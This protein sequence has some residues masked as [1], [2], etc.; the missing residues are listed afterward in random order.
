MRLKE[1]SLLFNII[2]YNDISIAVTSLTL[3]FIVTI[4]LFTN[5]D[6]EHYR[7][8][9]EKTE[10]TQKMQQTDVLGLKTKLL[11]IEYFDNYLAN[12]VGAE[13]LSRWD[14][15]NYFKTIEGEFDIKHLDI[16]GSKVS[17]VTNKNG[18]FYEKQSE[19]NKEELLTDEEN[20]YKDAFSPKYSDGIHRFVLRGRRF[21]LKSIK[22]IKGDENKALLMEIPV[23]F[24]TFTSLKTVI[25][26]DNDIHMV[27]LKDG[28]YIFGNYGPFTQGNFMG[29]ETKKVVFDGKDYMYEEVVIGDL[30]YSLGYFPLTNYDGTVEA[31][32]GVGLSQNSL[33]KLKAWIFL[34]IVLI[35]LLLLLINSYFFSRKFSRLLSPLSELVEATNNI[36]KGR[37]DIELK[38]SSTNEINNLSHSFK[39]MIKAIKSTETN[40]KKQNG[41]LIKTLHKINVT[42]SLLVRVRGERD[43]SKVLDIMLEGITSDNGL[44]FKRA[45]LFK[46]SGERNELVGEKA[47]FNNRFFSNSDDKNIGNRIETFKEILPLIKIEMNKNLFTT[48]LN[49]KEISYYNDR[50]YKY[51]FGNDLLMGFGINNFVIIP[52]LVEDEKYGAIIADNYN[53]EIKIEDNDIDLLH[54]ILMNLEVHFKNKTHEAEDVEKNREAAIGK[55]TERY[56]KS[57]HNFIDK[58]YDLLKDIRLDQ[59]KKEDAALLELEAFNVKREDEV[60]FEY[61]SKKAFQ[62]EKLGL[63]KLIEDLVREAEPIHTQ[64]GISIFSS[65]NFEILGDK[66]SMKRAIHE[67]LENSV[68]AINSNGGDG[69]IK[70]YLNNH[71]GKI[72]LEIVD[73]GGG[74]PKE[75]MSDKLF[76]PFISYKAKRSGL[77]LAYVKKVIKS[78]GGYVDLK[79]NNKTTKIIIELNGYKE[80]S[81]NVWERLRKNFKS[82]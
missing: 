32:I 56:L 19:G 25:N 43:N 45:F 78:H 26:N 55:I 62:F 31:Y 44:G 24:N 58:C 69:E 10:L 65:R 23:D 30:E 63:T 16:E 42:E 9:M 52:I 41:R 40:L 64:I 37:Y 50:G 20:F 81:K 18:K 80:E 79:S 34:A 76:E 71:K 7:A 14:K 29:N 22:K 61:S 48:A 6:D 28:K 27:V 59:V 35:T 82:T 8:T 13:S 38:E 21:H 4:Y 2:L 53:S 5:L 70:I 39:K 36:S 60:L 66:A 15:I 67:I 17:I 54:V 33:V 68:E 49:S 73:N 12:L 72:R 74:I 47:F 77:G 11:R 46:F 3:A 51:N 57:R 1:N 75:E